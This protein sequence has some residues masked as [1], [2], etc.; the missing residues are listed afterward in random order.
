MISTIASVVFATFGLLIVGSVVAATNARLKVEEARLHREE[1]QLRTVPQE[2]DRP[3]GDTGEGK[4]ME[5]APA[6]ETQ[7]APANDTSPEDG[8][9]DKGGDALDIATAHG[10]EQS[11]WPRYGRCVIV[12]AG[13]GKFVGIDATDASKASVDKA[14]EEALPRRRWW[15]RHGRRGGDSHHPV[16]VGMDAMP[17]LKEDHARKLVL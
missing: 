6:G 16:V 14:V 15:P 9:V 7:G 2:K 11:A 5:V 4:A 8:D 3:G 10:D 12:H 13:G 17:I 1:R